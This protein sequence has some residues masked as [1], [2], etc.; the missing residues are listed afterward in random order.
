M[1]N[2]LFG[3]VTAVVIAGGISLSAQAPRNPALT[4]T[5]CLTEKKGAT[6]TPN[7]GERTPVTDTYI[8]TNV[9]M[10]STSPVSGIALGSAY[11]VA[12]L[13]EAEL[14]KHLNHQVELLGSITP[15]RTKPTDN[16]PD[17]FATSLK[18]LAATCAAAK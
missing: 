11:R 10:A 6:V 8:L 2:R 3:A 18:M 9:K 15:P 16:T 14:K 12:G 13:A 17:F 5:G 7:A 4:I 1:R